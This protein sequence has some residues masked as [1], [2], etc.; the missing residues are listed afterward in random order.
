VSR[1]SALCA[2]RSPSLSLSHPLSLSLERAS[3]IFFGGSVVLV[4]VSRDLVVFVVV[5]VM[6]GV[7]GIGVV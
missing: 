5:L 3:M 1:Y 7:G 6:I 2:L 4:F